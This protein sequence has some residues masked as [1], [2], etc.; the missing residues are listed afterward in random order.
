MNEPAPLP[1]D[2]LEYLDAARD[3]E[4]APLATKERLLV[5]LGPFLPPG[6]GGGPS[7]GGP[8]IGAATT[9]ASATSSWLQGKLVVAAVSAMIGAIG[10]ATVHATFAPQRTVVVSTPVDASVAPPLELAP[11]VSVAAAPS[12][13]VPPPSI[14][15][16][17]ASAS[18]LP[19]EAPALRKS[20]M[21]AERILLEA[22]N[23]ALIRGDYATATVS[24]REH[25]RTYPRGE[26]AQERDILMAQAAKLLAADKGSAPR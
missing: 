22:A 13:E 19:S 16:A 10:G 24:L 23:A 25:A 15:V 6:G 2:L 17:V 9:A 18:S 11:V 5:R 1:D 7:I 26:L 21:R 20:S 4:P 8:S 12:V 14:S 3:P